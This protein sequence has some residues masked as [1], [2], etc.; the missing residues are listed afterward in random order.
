MSEVLV[1]IDWYLPGFKAGGPVTSCANMI[2]A[3]RDEIRF[4]VVTR[5][6]DYC[7]IQPYPNLPSDQWVERGSNEE[8]LYLSANKQTLGQIKNILRNSNCS[9]I[10]I[11][12][13]Y[14]LK[15]SL[16]PILANRL[17]GNKKPVIVASRGML[18]ESAIGVKK[19]RKKVFLGLARGLG[20]YKGVVFH[21]T[22]QK[23]KEDILREIGKSTKVMVAS[24]IAKSVADSP[25]PSQKEAGI[26]RLVSVA[27]IAPE[28][29]LRFILEVLKDVKANVLLDIYGSVY[30]SE[31]WNDCQQIVAQLPA[32][33]TVNYM[34]I[35]APGD[36]NHIIQHHDMLVLPSLGENY[37]H[38]IAESF[39][40]GRPVLISDQT[41]WKN[42][43][44]DH[45]G[46]DLPLEHS[47][48]GKVIEK[49]AVQD[50]S[51]FEQWC[52]GAAA[53]GNALSADV[54]PKQKHL[55]MF[56]ESSKNTG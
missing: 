48:F 28:K 56:L 16:Y 30:N 45:A 26:L 23:E 32:N 52:K 37:G 18:S 54:G 31:Y 34:G 17:S 6:T 44:N 41:P 22:N 35:A 40:A 51:R 25:S 38:V 14:S 1:F 7:D 42:L 39:L 43:E 3:L 11:N 55:E 9:S 19:F 15:F 33:I 13:I 12:G 50:A 29:N 10:Y 24:N 2:D 5:N 46:F 21:A 47:K 49:L 8:V 4:K 20:W 53:K 36:I 27:R